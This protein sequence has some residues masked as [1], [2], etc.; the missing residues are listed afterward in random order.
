MKITRTALEPK[1]GTIAIQCDR[2][3]KRYE[4]EMEIQ[5]FVHI[6]FIGGYSSVFGDGHSVAADIC[7]YC[8]K[9]IAGDFLYVSSTSLLL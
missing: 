4:D 7:Q 8:I 1:E 9:E 5:E 3:K 2:C 6:D